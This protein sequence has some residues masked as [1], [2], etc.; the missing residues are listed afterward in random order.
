[1]ETNVKNH[2]LNAEEMLQYHID[3]QEKE[4]I[5]KVNEE[6]TRLKKSLE[7]NPF[8]NPFKIISIQLDTPLIPEAL[9]KLSVNFEN[10]GYSVKYY[11]K[12]RP[13]TL[14]LCYSKK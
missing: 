6:I 11:D 8:S 12:I 7:K 1:M 3:L 5:K 10:I 14:D 4:V 2:M 9:E 13:I